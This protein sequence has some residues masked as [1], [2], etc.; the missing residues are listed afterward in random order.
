L[1]DDST[2]VDVKTKV[3]GFDGFAQGQETASD[4]YDEGSMEKV[5]DFFAEAPVCSK[6]YTISKNTKIIPTLDPL[7]PPTFV[8]GPKKNLT[9]RPRNI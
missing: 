2:G 4:L 3:C 8:S 7:I 9:I 1:K 6:T 5:S